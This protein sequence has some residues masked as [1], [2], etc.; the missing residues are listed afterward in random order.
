MKKRR[1]YLISFIIIAFALVGGTTVSY[2]VSHSEELANKFSCGTVVV[3]A[4]D[5]EGKL[6]ITG[7]GN[8]IW[9]PGE[10]KELELTVENT[11]SKRAYARARF[12]AD[13]RARHHTNIAGVTAKYLPTG[14][15]VPAEIKRSTSLTYSYG[16][17]DG[18][19]SAP[20]PPPQSPDWFTNYDQTSPL[21]LISAYIV[22]QA[23]GENG[24]SPAGTAD[25][26]G[27]GAASPAGKT[28]P[29]VNGLFYGDGDYLLYSPIARVPSGTTLYGYLEE[30]TD[31]TRTLYAALVVSRAVNDNVFDN[32]GGAY[33]KSAGWDRDRSFKHLT[34]SEFMGFLLEGH[35]IATN[36][37]V[38]WDWKQ[39]YA[40]QQ[41][42]NGAPKHWKNENNTSPTWASDHTAKAGEGTPPPGYVS[43]SS[44]VWNL[45]NYALNRLE[46]AVP[47][48]DVSLGGTRTWENWKSPFDPAYPVD[49]TKVDGYPD[50]GPITF[51]ETYGWEWPMVYEFSVDVTSCSP[52]GME[53]G[54]IS[55]HHSP[56]KN[57][58]ENEPFKKKYKIPGI[59]IVKEVSLD[60]G[61]TW[62][63]GTPCP[64]LPDP[65]PQGFAPK[66]RFTVKNTGGIEL[67]DIVVTDDV[68]GEIGTLASLAP[69]NSHVFDKTDNDWAAHRQELG[70]GNVSFHLAEGMEDWIEGDD[71]YF[72]YSEPIAPGE[73]VTLRVKACFAEDHDYR[74]A[75]LQINSYVE[76][77]QAS[78]NAVDDVWPEHPPLATI[79][80]GP[81][82]SVTKKADRS[83]AFAGDEINY[84]IRVTNNGNVILSNIAVTDEMLGISDSIASLAPGAS[85]VFDGSYTVKSSDT[86]TLE[87]TAAAS[88]N[89][90][91]HYISAAGSV[92][93][94]V[95]QADPSLEL[96]K[97]ADRSSAALDETIAYTITVTNDGNVTLNNVTVTDNMLG[98]SKNIAALAPGVSRSFSGSHTVVA[99]DFPGPFVNTASASTTYRGTS[100]SAQAS[101]SVELTT[102]IPFGNLN[103]GD[104]VE[105]SGVLFQK[106]GDNQVLLRGT[107]GTATQPNAINQ[108]QSY[109]GNFPVSIRTGSRLLTKNEA[110]SLSPSIRING[111][112]WWT[113][114]MQ[115]K[116]RRW[117]IDSSGK[118]RES[119]DT[120][121]HEIRPLLIL[122][123]NLSV[124]GGNGTSTDP[125]ILVISD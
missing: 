65:L 109:Y 51:S 75:L 116:N 11:G 76:A 57:G 110:E 44:L 79:P 4:G 28:V 38:A 37:D 2:F 58:V 46:P 111:H 56:A 34:N 66:F 86:G 61:T 96:K 25:S 13:W 22:E 60:G 108:G 97:Q 32:S 87:N 29:E 72:Y 8:N 120:S 41:D 74:D 30:K 123:P 122:K 27:G 26:G 80:T 100:V 63:S 5:A 83:S 3:G 104:Y 73:T 95:V 9:T 117:Y 82:L 35:N 77:V 70:P 114:G 59:S 88:A 19:D 69:G 121:V 55:S 119:G 52:S 17:Y 99:S 68:L 47:K 24:D 118:T 43:S 40:Y 31:G 102:A 12:E 81:S 23:G 90:E 89:H 45:N 78:H 7:N 42:E 112:D 93:V 92:F 39:C 84:T 48:W 50:T 103:V 94:T 54:N 124:S 16:D 1:L 115:N 62:Q 33:G 98:I 71:G 20:P 6:V 49:V 36:K 10:C 64:E 105:V 21:N 91:G 101:A 67:T 125:Y 53:L 107:A 106:I 18:G 113:S 14:E 15:T 85:Q